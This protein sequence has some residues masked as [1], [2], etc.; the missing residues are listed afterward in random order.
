MRRRIIEQELEGGGG[1]FS[2]PSL[3]SN[4]QLVMIEKSGGTTYPLKLKDG[5]II[6]SISLVSAGASSKFF[7]NSQIS[8]YVFSS[9]STVTMNIISTYGLEIQCFSLVGDVCSI[10]IDYIPAPTQIYPQL[11]AS[12]EFQVTANDENVMIDDMYIKPEYG[13][14]L[15]WLWYQPISQPDTFATISFGFKASVVPN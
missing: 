5:S 12:S 3:D 8:G 10:Y 14:I 11:P 1:Q 7:Y 13:S 9:G 4:V 15:Y 6:Q 2:V